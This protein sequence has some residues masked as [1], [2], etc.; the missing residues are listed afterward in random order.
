MD[1]RRSIF[2]ML[3]LQV[4]L[5]VYLIVPRSLADH[6]F[7]H[8]LGVLYVLRVDVYIEFFD[9]CDDLYLYIVVRFQKVMGA[10]GC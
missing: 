9:G 10:R 6:K 5:P 2:A 8:H 4:G 3:V 1:G 7:C